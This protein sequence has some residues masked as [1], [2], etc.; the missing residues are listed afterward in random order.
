MEANMMR[1]RMMLDAGTN[2]ETLTDTSEKSM[3]PE[4]TVIGLFRTSGSADSARIRLK[5][6]GFFENRIMLV[7]SAVT[8][9]ASTL[10]AH[11][12]PCSP[13]IDSMQARI[14]ARLYADAAA[15]RAA[16]ESTDALAHRQPTPDSIAGAEERL[17]D[18]STQT[19][20]AVKHAMERALA[21]DNSGDT[22]A[23]EQALAEAQSL[24]GP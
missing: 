1:L 20:A 9:V 23:C 17:H 19:V 24:I 10:G 4:K 5:P 12:G 16:K 15:G 8:L 18:V 2:G 11:A 6:E 13:A 3:N 21:A 7:L 22:K 14:D